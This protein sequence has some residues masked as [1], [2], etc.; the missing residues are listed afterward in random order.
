M[1]AALSEAFLFTSD[2]IILYRFRPL[3][4]GL[5]RVCMEAV[6]RQKQATGENTRD[7]GGSTLK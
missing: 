6:A 5:K 3:A 4:R 1:R 7:A 2:E